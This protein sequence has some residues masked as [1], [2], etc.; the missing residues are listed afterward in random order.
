MIERGRLIVVVAGSG[1]VPLNLQQPLDPDGD[2]VNITVTRIPALGRLRLDDRELAET[3]RLTVDEMAL[4]SF[5]APRHA[6]GSSGSLDF[7]L[8]DD[9]GGTAAMSVVL[10]AVPPPNR[11]PVVGEAQEVVATV[12]GAAVPLGIPSPSD[13]DGDPLEAV[14]MVL[15]GAGWCAPASA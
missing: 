13:P 5:E 1:P 3:D 15:P 4:L 7:R 12:G 6:A 10:Q 2:R 11:S 9:R 14:V 8:E